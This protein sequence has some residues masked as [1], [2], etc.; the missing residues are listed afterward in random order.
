MKLNWQCPFCN[1]DA[2]VHDGDEG[3]MTYF[4]H[5]FE[6]GNKFGR[7]Y[8]EGQVI[9]CPNQLCREYSLLLALGDQKRV[10]GEWKQLKPKRVWQLIPD[11]S[12]KVFPSYIPKPLLDDCPLSI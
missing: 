5:T 1:H 10:A 7:Q 4:D 2:I 11:S 9:V 3:T 8:L 6:H 12:A